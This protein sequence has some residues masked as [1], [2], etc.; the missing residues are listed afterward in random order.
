MLELL[1]KMKNL[2]IILALCFVSLLRGDDWPFS[3]ESG[4][5]QIVNLIRASS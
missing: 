2:C 5:D 4:F 3:G 1:A